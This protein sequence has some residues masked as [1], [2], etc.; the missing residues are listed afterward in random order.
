MN[1]RDTGRQPRG[2]GW[3]RTDEGTRCGNLDHTRPRSA[4]MKPQG[5]REAFSTPFDECDLH[6]KT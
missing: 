5:P 4:H 2:G 6:F 1:D 3:Y